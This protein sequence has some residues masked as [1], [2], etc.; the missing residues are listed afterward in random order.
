MLVF[1]I[2]LISQS[3][4]HNV[5]FLWQQISLFRPLQTWTTKSQLCSIHCW[6]REAL[7]CYITGLW[8]RLSL[9]KQTFWTD[10]LP[11]SLCKQGLG[12]LLKRFVF[13]VYTVEAHYKV[14]VYTTLQT[15]VKLQNSPL[16]ANMSHVTEWKR[17]SKNA[18]APQ[19]ECSYKY[20][21]YCVTARL[22]IFFA[23]LFTALLNSVYSF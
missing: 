19:T 15:Y 5:I 22:N 20:T 21:M 8:S 7:Q 2:Y 18:A 23:Q 9:S 12:S 16:L 10:I 4:A 11:V 1:H 17:W 6:A 14:I 3:T 13:V